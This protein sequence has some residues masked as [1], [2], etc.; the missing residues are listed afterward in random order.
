ML[1]SGDETQIA[2]AAGLAKVALYSV[3]DKQTYA[4]VLEEETKAGIEGGK[5]YTL[6]P[7]SIR[8]DALG[9]VISSAPF[10]PRAVTLGPGQTAVEYVPG[11]GGGGGGR[12]ARRQRAAAF[13]VR[14]G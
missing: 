11:G 13:G 12:A 3:L 4:R 10:A 7:G 1:E 2:Q 9:N 6:A 8:F 5:P 14:A